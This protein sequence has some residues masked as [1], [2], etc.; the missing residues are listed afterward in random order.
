MDIVVSSRLSCWRSVATKSIVPCELK[1]QLVSVVTTKGCFLYLRINTLYS[2]SDY[3]QSC[4]CFNYRVS[5][6]MSYESV[7]WCRFNKTRSCFRP[8]LTI[9]EMKV[10]EIRLSEH[11]LFTCQCMICMLALHCDLNSVTAKC[12]GAVV[13]QWAFEYLCFLIFHVSLGNECQAYYS[14]ANYRT[15][16]S[17]RIAQN[18]LNICFTWLFIDHLF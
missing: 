11:S 16:H 3:F 4:L 15:V 18:M 12:P 5:L 14:K 9:Q 13:S 1:L 6:N 7:S 2:C 10:A 8:A 17:N